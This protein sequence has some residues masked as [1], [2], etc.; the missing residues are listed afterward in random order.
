MSRFDTLIS[1]KFEVLGQSGDER[2]C[3]CPWHDDTGKPNLYVNAVTGLYLCFA[4]G[5][6]GSLAKNLNGDFKV[7]LDDL[8][9][10]LHNKSKTEQLSERPEAWLNQFQFDHPY[11]QERGFSEDIIR[12]FRLGY[13]PLTDMVTIP[14]R[15]TRGKVLGVIRRRLDDQRP[16]YMHPKGWKS[17]KDLYGAWMMR[18]HHFTRVALVEGPLDAIAC[19]DAHVPALGLHG[20]RLTDDQAKI[21]RGLGITTVVA[22]TDR[23]AA[24]DQAAHEIKQQLPGLSVMVGWYR[25]EW[26][27]SDPGSLSGHRLRVMFLDALPWHKA[28]S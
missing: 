20:A 18:K 7:T 19:W 22:M 4:C 17:G 11:W 16:K 23:D 8:R 10:K 5:A 2:V 6:K 1:A 13:D 24:G 27:G 12:Q 3:R 21:I 14:I 25:P 28:W 15:T 9:N 26:R